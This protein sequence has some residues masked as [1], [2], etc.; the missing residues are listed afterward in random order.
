MAT[1][2]TRKTRPAR[3]SEA[4]AWKM[5]FLSGYDFFSDLEIIGIHNDTEARLAAP[6]AWRQYGPQFMAEFEPTD[7]VPVPWALEQFG[8]PD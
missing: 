4:R 3:P 8:E 5:L 6:E 7:A 1:K 2:R